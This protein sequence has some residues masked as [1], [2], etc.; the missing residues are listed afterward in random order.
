VEYETG[1]V[2][3]EKLANK[4]VDAKVENK[5]IALHYANKYNW[6]IKPVGVPLHSMVVAMLFSKRVDPEIIDRYNM[7]LHKVKQDGTYNEIYT[8]WFGQ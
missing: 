5:E 7:A 8:R 3:L 4:E 2:A 6:D 1:T